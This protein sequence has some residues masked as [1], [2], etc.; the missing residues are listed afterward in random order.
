MSIKR[1][2]I[3]V[4]FISYI[5][6]LYSFNFPCKLVDSKLYDIKFNVFLLIEKVV[7]KL[8]L[9]VK[10]INSKVYLTTKYKF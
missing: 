3:F 6:L 4:L 7:L 5:S 10:T 9:I 1:I 2:H 8:F